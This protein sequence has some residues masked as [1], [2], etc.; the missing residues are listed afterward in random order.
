MDEPLIGRLLLVVAL[1][2]AAL[3]G[4]RT[5]LDGRHA[6]GGPVVDEERGQG[7]DMFAFAPTP[8]RWMQEIRVEGGEHVLIPIDITLQDEGAVQ[9]AMPWRPPEPDVFGLPGWVAAHGAQIRLTVDFDATGHVLD[10][11][12]PDAYFDDLDE[13]DSATADTLRAL[14]IEEQVDEVLR[15]QT[16]AVMSQPSVDGARWTAEASFPGLG[17]L[18]G[19]SGLLEYSVGPEQPCPEPAGG[20]ACGPVTITGDGLSAKML[21]GR[22]TGMEWQAE[23]E[24]VHDGATRRVRRRLLRPDDAPVP[25][26]P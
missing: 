12:G 25:V 3:L 9:M 14:L 7:P 6:G 11:V 4:T 23:L 16:T 13:T 1:V 24:R 19:W 5:W 22:T 18:P 21:I 10:V 15:W 17:A 20:E 2:V 26:L 8:G